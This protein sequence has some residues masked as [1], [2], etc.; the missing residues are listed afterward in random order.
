MNRIDNGGGEERNA[1]FK[2]LTCL[3]KAPYREN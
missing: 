2:Y 1:D 3:E